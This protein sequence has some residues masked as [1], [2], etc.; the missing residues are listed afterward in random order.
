MRKILIVLSLVI[1]NVSFAADKLT[2]DDGALATLLKTNP[3]VNSES[4]E[5]STVIDVIA[6]WLTTLIDNE[7]RNGSLQIVRNSCEAIE[8]GYRC[9]LSILSEDM[10]LTDKG[11]YVR[12][13]DA[14][15]SLLMIE[16]K[17]NSSNDKIVGPVRLIIAG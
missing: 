16:Y 17:T 1:A 15:E 5:S 10:K 11:N 6:P 2:I 4:G 8:K 7:N 3:K 9:T 13:V 14:T 12:P